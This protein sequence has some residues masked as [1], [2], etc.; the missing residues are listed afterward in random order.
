MVLPAHTGADYVI[1]HQTRKGF[2]ND[3]PL[4]HGV[5]AVSVVMTIASVI[6]TVAALLL[7]S[8]LGTLLGL[9]MNRRYQRRLDRIDRMRTV[10]VSDLVGSAGQ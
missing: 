8:F 5:R 2:R 7:P 1:L 9:A 10:P 4:T 6:F 3:Q